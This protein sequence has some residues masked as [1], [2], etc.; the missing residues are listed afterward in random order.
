MN[1]E[2]SLFHRTP[3]HKLCSILAQLEYTYR[4][5]DWTDKGVPFFS[6]IFMSLKFYQRLELMWLMFRLHMCMHACM[7]DCNFHFPFRELLPLQETVVSFGKIC[8]GISD[9][10]SGLT[11][12]ALVGSLKQCVIVSFVLLFLLHLWGRQLYMEMAQSIM[13]R[14]VW[15]S[16]S[17][18]GLIVPHLIIIELF[19]SF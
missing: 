15:L 4:I 11:Q 8:R 5:R 10:M 13:M 12:P 1:V 16:W 7:H 3:V 17:G 14:E 18:A 2:S 9:A 19:G 6:G